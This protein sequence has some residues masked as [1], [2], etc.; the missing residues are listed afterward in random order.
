MCIVYFLENNY[1]SEL[2]YSIHKI[3]Y[4]YSI[5]NTYYIHQI[6]YDRKEFQSLI[7]VIRPHT[8]PGDW[9]GQMMTQGKTL[10][11]KR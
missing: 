8:E 7:L 11:E 1:I 2:F 10:L 4:T 6:Q 9:K 5:Q 3:Q